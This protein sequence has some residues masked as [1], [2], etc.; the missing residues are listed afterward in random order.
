MPISAW[1]E[2]G[3]GHAR[4]RRQFLVVAG[5]LS[6]ASP[7]VLQHPHL[8]HDHHGTSPL[9][10]PSRAPPPTRRRAARTAS[11]RDPHLTGPHWTHAPRIP[12]SR[13]S[14]T[15]HITPAATPSTRR[16]SLPP[17]P[18]STRRHLATVARTP[19]ASTRH[20]APSLSAGARIRRPAPL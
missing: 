2:R 14:S 8:L 7:R 3:Q 15:P 11:P 12:S 13:S 20:A 6:A 10:I 18:A 17:A 5:D 9:P 16:P 4:R 1:S 19:T